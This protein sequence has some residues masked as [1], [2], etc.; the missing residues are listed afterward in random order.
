MEKI[1]VIGLGPGNIDYTLPAA[2]K[3]IEAADLLVGSKRSLEALQIKNK[4]CFYYESNMMQMLDY[5]DVQSREKKVAVVVTGDSGFY[6]LLDAVGR[7]VGTERIE[8]IPGISA[9]QYLFA[10]L[11]RSYKDFRL[12]SLHGRS[13]DYISLLAQGQSVFL[14]TDKENGPD[15]I[16]EAIMAAGLDGIRLTVGE[17]LSYDCE[18]II[19][20]SPTDIKSMGFDALSVVIAEPEEGK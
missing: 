9:F 6:S 3:A 18:R 15:R 12:L 5:I 14:L 2:V 4:P 16:A 1:K 20:G 11:G 8:A 19:S 7:H 10:R 13:M 17:N